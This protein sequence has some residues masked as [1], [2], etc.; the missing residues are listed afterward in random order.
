[1]GR[2]TA[3]L[4]SI[5]QKKLDQRIPRKDAFEIVR[6]KNHRS[7]AEWYE[8]IDSIN[9]RFDAN[10]PQ[11]WTTVIAKVQEAIDLERELLNGSVSEMGLRSCTVNAFG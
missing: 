6:K 2:F 5:L 10:P 3:L 8:H 7:I 9:D 11:E 4:Q 1:V